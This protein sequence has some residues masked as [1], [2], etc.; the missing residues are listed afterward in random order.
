MQL[1]RVGSA[2]AETSLVSLNDLK[3]KIRRC[4]NDPFQDFINRDIEQWRPRLVSV[5]NCGVT[6]TVEHNNLPLT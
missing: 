6:I 4:L 3:E 2:S 5:V 1:R